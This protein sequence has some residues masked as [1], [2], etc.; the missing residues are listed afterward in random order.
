MAPIRFCLTIASTKCVFNTLVKPLLDYTDAAWG[1]LSEGWKND[2]QRIQN[3]G[4]RIILQVSS[5]ENTFFKLGWLPLMQWRIIQQCCLV[6][7]CLHNLAP[8]Y[9]AN[10]YTRNSEVHRYGTRSRNDIHIPRFKLEL[11]KRMFKYAGAK[12]YNELPGDKNS[13]YF[14]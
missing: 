12:H 13:Y 4:A 1:E 8:E 2:L 9:F 3:R 10:Y 14:I 11:G 5:S 6:F 7:K